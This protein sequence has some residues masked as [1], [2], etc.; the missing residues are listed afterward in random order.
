[1]HPVL[2]YGITFIVITTGLLFIFEAN[3]IGSGYL[4][5][6]IAIISSGLVGKI[7]IKIFPSNDPMQQEIDIE[8]RKQRSNLYQREI[9]F[10]FNI[11]QPD[12]KLQPSPKRI[13]GNL[14]DLFMLDEE[15]MLKRLKQHF[16]E[17]F[18]L[19][20]NQPLP[21][22]VEEINIKYNDWLNP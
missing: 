7:L 12:P 10:L 20:I 8:N 1:M 9:Q 21:D 4:L 2:I 19:Q 16:G 13:G 11:V 6:I 17:S 5:L 15:K 18:N 14:T 3:S 22:L